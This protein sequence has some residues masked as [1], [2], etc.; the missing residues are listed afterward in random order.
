MKTNEREIT[1]HKPIADVFEFTLEP[2]NTSKWRDDAGT[3]TVN[4][5]Q[6]GLGTLYS[7]NYG[8]LE[9][10]DYDR[11]T[12]FELTNHTT[13]LQCSYTY[14]KIDENSTKIIYFEYMQDGSDLAEPMK[15]ES[16]EKL[17]ELIQ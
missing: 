12:F 8:E 16:F 1:I 13:T 15:Q 4:T 9:V 10:T 7:N 11:N 5:D 2:S 3:K 6:I 17:K 14:K